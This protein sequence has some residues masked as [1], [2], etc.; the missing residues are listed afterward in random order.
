MTST[1]PGGRS[2]STSGPG[3]VQSRGAARN[4]RIMGVGNLTPE[5]PH[6]VAQ[7]HRHLRDR[8]DPF[9]PALAGAA[10][11]GGESVPGRLGAEADGLADGPPSFQLEMTGE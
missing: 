8:L 11:G 7:R 4:R 2:G 10:I 5:P 9:P 1:G 6:I 3:R